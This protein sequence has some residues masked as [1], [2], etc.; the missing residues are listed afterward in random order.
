MF[1][2]IET[3]L[4]LAGTMFI[5]PALNAQENPWLTKSQVRNPWLNGSNTTESSQSIKTEFKDSSKLVALSDS[6]ILPSRE[7]TTIERNTHTS[8]VL[9]EAESR[10]AYPAKGEFGGSFATGLILNI[11]SLPINALIGTAPTIKSKAYEAKFK[12]ENPDVTRNELKAFKRG[13]RKKRAGRA[14]AG[15]ACGILAQIALIISIVS[16]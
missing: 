9:I 1:R 4:L 8:L 12:E 2:K 11:L 14:A 16:T 7:A 3:L 10:D 13:I 15:T 6:V 5:L